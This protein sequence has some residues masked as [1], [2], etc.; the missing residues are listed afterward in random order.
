MVII[1]KGVFHGT[2]N[3]GPDDLHLV[4]I[5]VPRNKF[6]LVRLHDRYGRRGEHYQTVHATRR[7]RRHR[8]P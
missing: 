4:E 6:D 5:E 2:T 8:T 3:A 7:P 1:G